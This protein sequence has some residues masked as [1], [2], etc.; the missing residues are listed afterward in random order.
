[1]NKSCIALMAGATMLFAAGAAYAQSGAGY[2]AGGYASPGYGRQGHPGAGQVLRCESHNHRRQHCRVDTRGGVTLV[3]Q[4]SNQRCVQGRNWGHD[5]NGVWVT[6]GCRAEFAVGR[7]AGWGTGQRPPPS[8][9]PGHVVR[10]ESSNH[11]HRRC[12]IAVRQGVTLTRQ[13]SDASCIRGRTWGWD[14]SGI[15]VDRGCRAEFA[16]R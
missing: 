3:R 6:N 2:G 10:C 4:L 5:R 14:R 15:W 13:L 9:A 7:G 16:V 11:R 8:H 1:M 12:N